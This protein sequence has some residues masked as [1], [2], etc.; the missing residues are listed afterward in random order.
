MRMCRFTR[1]HSSEWVKRQA[2][3][4]AS[5]LP[6]DRAE[7]LAVLCLAREIVV[8]LGCVWPTET[9]DALPADAPPGEITMIRLV[10]SDPA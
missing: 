10:S 9:C 5:Q 7:A 3:L 1:A 2:A 8:N 4:I 6:E